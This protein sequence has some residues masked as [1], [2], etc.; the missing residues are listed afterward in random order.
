MPKAA[1]SAVRKPVIKA[2]VP[3]ASD[4]WLNQATWRPPAGRAR[5][6]RQHL[7]QRTSMTMARNPSVSAW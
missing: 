6:H 7:H 5:H 1:G 3:P 2:R 4:R